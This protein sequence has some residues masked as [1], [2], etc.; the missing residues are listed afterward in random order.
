MQEDFEDYCYRNKL[1]AFNKVHLAR[2]L[3]SLY[4]IRDVKNGSRGSQKHMWKGIALREDLRAS[5]Q[6][7]LGLYGDT[8]EVKNGD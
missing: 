4:N 7:D 5:G 6:L 8:D 2:E 3:A 1:P